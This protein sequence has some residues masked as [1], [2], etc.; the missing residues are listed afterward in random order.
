LAITPQLIG[1]DFA[2]LGWYPWNALV[3]YEMNNICGGSLILPNWV[4]T[5]A[6][7]AGYLTFYSLHTSPGT[8]KHC[9]CRYNFSVTLGNI[10]FNNPSEGFVRQWGSES[11]RHELF[12]PSTLVHD[13]ALL[14]LRFPVTMTGNF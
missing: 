13:I 4:L 11:Y 5:A 8:T 10:N 6:Q 12:N 3:F 1:G 9:H 14:K 7:C 2:H